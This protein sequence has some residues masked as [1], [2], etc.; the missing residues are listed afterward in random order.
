MIQIG[1]LKKLA[2]ERVQ[3]GTGVLAL[4]RKWSLALD[5]MIPN[6]YTHCFATEK[7]GTSYSYGLLESNQDR[8]VTTKINISVITNHVLHVYSAGNI[9]VINRYSLA[10]LKIG[11]SRLSS[12]RM[13]L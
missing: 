13:A 12:T 9:A 3:A 5:H 6:V 1:M 11:E 8:F 4:L 2:R 7:L 10:V